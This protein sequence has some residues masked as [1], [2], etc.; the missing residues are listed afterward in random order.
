M[1]LSACP[2][3]NDGQAEW[4]VFPSYIS[5]FSFCCRRSRWKWRNIYNCTAAGFLQP[6]GHNYSAP[7]WLQAYLRHPRP[8]HHGYFGRIG[9]DGR[10]AH[11][12]VV[13]YRSEIHLVYVEVKS[14]TDLT[15]RKVGSRI[16]SRAPR[17]ARVLFTQQSVKLSVGTF[18]RLSSTRCDSGR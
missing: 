12:A 10:R 14:W 9:E 16:I 6:R 18:S 15:R 4:S 11:G 5:T 3:H 2:A 8:P 13:A 1:P 7:A 17:T